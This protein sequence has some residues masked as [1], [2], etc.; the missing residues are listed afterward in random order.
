MWRAM[1]SSSSLVSEVASDEAGTQ[2]DGVNLDELDSPARLDNGR[3]A[4]AIGED[5]PL[6]RRIAVQAKKKALDDD[7]PAASDGRDAAQDVLQ[8]HAQDTDG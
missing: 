7:P 3:Q 2:G 4:V 6:G 8:R 5:F 1:L